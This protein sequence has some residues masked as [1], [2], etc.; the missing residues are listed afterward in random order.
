MEKFEYEI[1]WINPSVLK[2]LLNEWG[3]KSWELCSIDYSSGKCIFKRRL[4]ESD[5][6]K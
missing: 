6:N 5:K 4:K 2:K 3:D 1:V